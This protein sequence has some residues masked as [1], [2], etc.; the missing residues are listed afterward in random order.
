MATDWQTCWHICGR[1]S[2]N[3]GIASGP[4][5]QLDRYATSPPGGPRWNP[6]SKQRLTPYDCHKFDGDSV[7][8]EVGRTVCEARCLPRKELFESW[9][10]ARRVLR[11][12]RGGPVLDVACGH[13][14]VAWFVALIDRRTPSA[15]CV[16]P[17][18]PANAERLAAVLSK[19]WPDI[20]ARV[21]YDR[22]GVNE[23]E[24]LESSRVV[25]VHACGDLTDQVLERSMAA[26]ARVAVLPCC[27]DHR[28]LD[29]G[30]MSG[31]M[32]RAVAID[33]VRAGRL[34]AVGYRV[35]TS[36]IPVHLT[37]HNRLLGGVPPGA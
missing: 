28:E 23:V 20:G 15:V 33:A 32:P 34:R 24:I 10:V 6:G 5:S 2:T 17:K 21:R 27:H 13:G 8:D 4:R 25:A 35:W 30:G 12:A 36:T 29:D 14:L 31:W 3:S 19:R 1:M 9:E 26:R 11:K 37:P 7:L 22:V 16:D 18:F